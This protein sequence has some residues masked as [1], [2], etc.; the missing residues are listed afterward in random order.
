MI[1]QPFIPINIGMASQSTSIQNMPAFMLELEWLVIVTTFGYK[2]LRTLPSWATL[3]TKLSLIVRSAHRALG[4]A[5]RSQNWRD[6]QFAAS[7]MSPECI[8]AMAALHQ[9]FQTVEVVVE[10]V[11][12]EEEEVE[13]EEVE[14]EEVE[15]VEEVAKTLRFSRICKSFVDGTECP[16][17]AVGRTCNFA[18]SIA[19][20]E[21]G[22]RTCQWSGRCNRMNGERPCCCRHRLVAGF[23]T[24]DQIIDRMNLVTELPRESAKVAKITHPVTWVEAA[25]VFKTIDD[26]RAQAEQDSETIAA[27]R[28][29]ADQDADKIAELEQTVH[30]AMTLLIE[31]NMLPRRTASNV[32]NSVSSQLTTD[33]T[34]DIEKAQAGGHWSWPTTDAYDM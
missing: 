8:A 2:R 13:V 1:F 27:L 34:I 17:E 16:H 11:E 7:A 29:K 24:T 26:L 4:D 32:A 14:V 21:K 28:A 20:L 3:S 6:F 19:D 10:E 33:L 18:H 23:E 12:V 31:H 5:S 15:V 25:G 22:V 9:D 30:S